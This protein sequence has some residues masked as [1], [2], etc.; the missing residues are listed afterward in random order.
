MKNNKS[1]DRRI[2]L[3]GEESDDI[4]IDRE[5]EH[6]IPPLSGSELADLHRSLDQDGCRDA[7]VVWKGHNTL[8]DGHNRL[9]WCREKKSPFPVIELEFAD[10]EAAKLFIIHEQLGRRNLSPGAESYLRG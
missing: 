10:R 7:L 6:L 4:K 1:D 2:C 5:F 8:V 3:P 9:K